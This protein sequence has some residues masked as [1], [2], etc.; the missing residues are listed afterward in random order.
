MGTFREVLGTRLPASTLPIE[1]SWLRAALR[2]CCA[3]GCHARL[4]STVTSL[5]RV[6]ARRYFELRV[7]MRGVRRGQYVI[8][9]SLLLGFV[10]MATS[11]VLYR[12]MMTRPALAYRALKENLLSITSDLDRAL[13]HSL[14]L[15]S[16]EFQLTG[17]R[18]SARAQGC[19]F[20]S[21]WVRSVLVAYS[22]LGLEMELDALEE[23]Y[24][25]VVFVFDWN[26]DVGISYASSRFR[27]NIAGYGFAGWVG[28]RIR[29]VMLTI[30]RNSITSDASSGLST[31][32][33]QVVE[34]MDGVLPNLSAEDVSISVHVCEGLWVPASSVGL[35]Y[36][37][38]GNYTVVFTPRVNE[39]THGLVLV[40]TTPDDGITVSAHHLGVEHSQVQVGSL[41]ENGSSSNEGWAQLGD[42]VFTSLPNATE[43]HAGEYIVQYYP[44]SGCRF[45]NW[46]TSGAVT[47]ENTTSR[48]TALTVEGNGDLTAFYAFGAEIPSEEPNGTVQIGL[49]S[50]ELSSG[51][52]NMGMIGL[53][54]IDYSLPQELVGQPLGFHSVTFTPPNGSQIFLE[55]ETSGDVFVENGT[56]GSTRVLFNG[57]GT[58]TAV[59]LDP[60][61]ASGPG[62]STTNWDVLCVEGDYTLLPLCMWSGDDGKLAPTFNMG[63]NGQAVNISSPL[64]PP[65]HIAEQV[66][67]TCVV[68]P[69][70][71]SRVKDITLRLGFLWND[72]YYPLGMGTFSIVAEGN[73]RLP[74][75]MTSG[76]FPTEP[77]VIPENSTIVLT[78]EV[79]FRPGGWGTFFLYHGSTWPSSIELGG[80]PV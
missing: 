34:E 20:I 36:N 42:V 80:V 8:V 6:L 74:L 38:G 72:T 7:L 35:V 21:T 33:F 69:N 66:N 12:G 56:S 48:L 58:V 18:G 29:A 77:L 78:V 49:R 2:P 26:E 19:A 47:V 63:E 64:T 59:Y 43:V 25:D 9:A 27:V 61:S 51:E 37:G 73:Y 57:N 16:R 31:V 44:S 14:C 71:P 3:A 17:S 40:V 15:A 30:D 55:W 45:V 5:I 24:T 62:I 23:G 39:A 76:D 13:S 79:G 53:G 52:L 70:P 32:S 22:N 10:V 60:C 46:T 41:H 67:V 68:R 75:D 54:G 50:I 65:L 1:V 28:D 4:R 11:L